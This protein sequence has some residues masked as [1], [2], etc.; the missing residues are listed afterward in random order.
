MTE[1]SDSDLGE[2]PILVQVLVVGDQAPTPQDIQAIAK[3][4]M[5]MG[6]FGCDCPRCREQR[7]RNGN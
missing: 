4:V 3:L 7:A 6:G 5:L 2:R 1:P